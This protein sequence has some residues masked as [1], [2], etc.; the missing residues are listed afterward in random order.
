NDEDQRGGSLTGRRGGCP[1]WQQ[2][3]KD[4]NRKRSEQ[5][6]NETAP[7]FKQ[8]EGA[9]L[10]GGAAPFP[11]RANERAPEQQNGRQAPEAIKQR[12]RARRRYC[13]K[14]DAAE[15]RGNKC[16]RHEPPGG[17]AI[18]ERPARKISKH[19]DGPVEREGCAKLQIGE[20]ENV[21][22]GGTEYSRNG[23]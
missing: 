20:P 13:G 9:P 19:R 7:A 4:R 10:A 17:V 18:G 21:K 15:R 6:R 23:E 11:R 2:G 12:E 16:G 22:K 5:R 3:G 1:G 14:D 8:A